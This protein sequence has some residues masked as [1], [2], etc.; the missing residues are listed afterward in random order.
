MGGGD[1]G[2]TP[3][4]PTTPEA[5][6][7]EVQRLSVAFTSQPQARST[8]TLATTVLDADG[9]PMSNVLV[10]WSTS[11][12]Y[13]LNGT[14][15]TDA[16]G[17]AS[18]QITYDNINGASSITVAAP[19][20]SLPQYTY[21][22]TIGGD[23]LVLSTYAV[24]NPVAPRSTYD[25]I[26]KVVND[27]GQPVSGVSLT[28]NYSA[29][30]QWYAST[31]VTGADGLAHIQ[32]RVGNVSGSAGWSTYLSGVANM[33]GSVPVVGD[34]W[35]ASDITLSKDNI[36]KNTQTVA[37]IRVTNQNGDPMGGVPVTWGGSSITVNSS[38][39]VSN[40][41]GYATATVTPYDSG[42][43]NVTANI[44]DVRYISKTITVTP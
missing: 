4:T 40:A 38:D 17:I 26:G 13:L 27:K 41:S 12:G 28:W 10:S 36:P 9:N 35:F 23:V 20:I 11:R 44:T 19:S 39:S 21:N 18:N 31:T 7:P 1:N 5:P 15:T 33:S 6:K 34:K 2:T 3:T 24:T 37:T 29:D 14:S 32:G 25:F 22:Y 42:Y 16:S 8:A 43:V 30:I